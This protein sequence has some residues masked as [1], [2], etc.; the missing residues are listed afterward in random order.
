ME[1]VEEHGDNPPLC[2]S[3]QELQQASQR[4]EEIPQKGP[5]Q[6]PFCT[7]L[8]IPEIPELK[9]SAQQPAS[10]STPS[11]R[12]SRWLAADRRDDSCNG[13]CNTTNTIERAAFNAS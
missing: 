13:H 8:T 3:H 2:R 11:A 12:R 6:L 7:L 10:D 9:A 4:S 1:G 5:W